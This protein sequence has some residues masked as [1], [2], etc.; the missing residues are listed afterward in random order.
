[1][2]EPDYAH[3]VTMM[4]TMAHAY[5]IYEE[6]NTWGCGPAWR[7]VAED[8]EAN[9]HFFRYKNDGSVPERRKYPSPASYYGG[10]G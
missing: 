7:A 5:R 2:D 1:M 6:G 3:P 10:A 9:A 4:D 8:L